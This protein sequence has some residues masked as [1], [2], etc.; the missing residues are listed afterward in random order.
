MLGLVAVVL[1]AA[2][3]KLAAPGATCVGLAP[4]LCEVYLEH[5]VAVLSASG[6]LRVTT[7][8]DV[9][10]LLGLERQQQ[11]LGC[12][13]SGTSCTAELAGALGVDGVLTASVAKTGASYLATLRVLRSRDGAAWAQASSRLASEEALQAWLD[14][15]ARAFER[16]LAPA[17]PGL[18][19]WVPG[20]AG[21]ACLVA[22][23]ALFSWSKVDAA[24]LQDQANGLAPGQLRDVVARGKVTQPLGLALMGAGA[25][26]LAASLLW[27]ALAPSAPAQVALVPA[28]GGAVLTVGGQLP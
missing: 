25:A 13:D 21:G 20:L 17:A 7:A 9:A 24:S 16:R 27:V 8:K 14:D 3:L 5:F 18:E 22:G 2:P 26:G 23:V 10:E 1:V 4:A 6:R 19:R 11:L 28:P 15:T 12:A